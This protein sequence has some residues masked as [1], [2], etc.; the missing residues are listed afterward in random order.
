[1]HYY[2]KKKI[3]RQT[4][5]D[6]FFHQTKE[7]KKN[8]SAENDSQRI[9]IYRDIVGNKRYVSTSSAT[10]KGEKEEINELNNT[11]GILHEN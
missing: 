11:K 10:Q 2:N 6:F 1:M 3:I 4:K 9:A 5:Q 8:R 7:Y